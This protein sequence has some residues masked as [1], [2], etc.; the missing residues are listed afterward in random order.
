MQ[1]FASLPLVITNSATY[2]FFPT[3]MNQPKPST[4]YP[5]ISFYVWN[6]YIYY[7]SQAVS[8]TFVKV[9]GV[10]ELCSNDS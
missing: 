7:I 10:L 8:V 4:A 9:Y 1:D 3:F 5:Q 6:T 2:T